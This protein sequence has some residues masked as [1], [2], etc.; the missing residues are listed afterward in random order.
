MWVHQADLYKQTP[1]II[2]DKHLMMGP[3]CKPT[4]LLIRY[5]RINSVKQYRSYRNAEQDLMNFGNVKL[6][7]VQDIGEFIKNK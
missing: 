5:T 6:D 1:L 4:K 3:D 7:E 2:R